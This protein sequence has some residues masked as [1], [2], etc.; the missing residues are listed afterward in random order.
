M[1]VLSVKHNNQYQYNY[2]GRNILQNIFRDITWSVK[3]EETIILPG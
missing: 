3:K 2:S 1:P